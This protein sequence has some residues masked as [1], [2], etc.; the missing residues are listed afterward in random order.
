MGPRSWKRRVLNLGRSLT[1]LFQAEVAA[2][3]ADLVASAKRVGAGSILL[4]VGG[5]FLLWALGTLTLTAFEAL[6]TVLPRWGAAA[7]LTGLLGI[8][9]GILIGAGRARIR[10]TETP[11]RTIRRHIEENREWWEREILHEADEH[12]DAD[13][14]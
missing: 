2:L 3:R 4:L 7:I 9:G 11:A 8:V 1:E 12:G 5:I 6:S 13:A 10:R 14:D